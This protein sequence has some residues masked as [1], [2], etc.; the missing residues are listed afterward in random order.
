MEGRGDPGLAEGEPGALGLCCPPLP[1][2][3]PL[4]RP[5]RPWP[6][7]TCC[8]S[9]RVE[10]LSSHRAHV[11]PSPGRGSRGRGYRGRE[12]AEGAPWL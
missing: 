6:T 8:V 9:S 5:V 12:R 2:N 10:G 4:R 3:L 11:P 1:V 7:G